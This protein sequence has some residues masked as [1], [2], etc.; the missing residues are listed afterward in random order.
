MINQ[1]QRYSRFVL[2]TLVI[3]VPL[4]SLA[5]PPWQTGVHP[6]TGRRFAG[7]M[8]MA[9][10]PWL[11]RSEREEEEAPS[12][13][14]D[15]LN[16]R[17]GMVVADVGAGVGYF[18]EPI[19]KRVGPTGL[20]YANDIQPAM[21]ELLKER[22]S[23]AGLR[24]YHTVLG[25]EDDPRLPS[26]AID[27][28]LLVDV[29]HEFSRPQEMLQKMRQAL[30]PDGRLVLLEYRKEDPGIPIRREH[31]MSVAEVKAEVEPEGFQLKTVISNRLPRQHVLIFVKRSM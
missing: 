15:L 19:A 21:L 17:Q 18:V 12:L 11:E 3:L 25:A 8:G 16:L 1:K 10:A 13:A 24:N 27:L 20:V 30:K 7:V 4:A 6:V 22:M 14:I 28:I 9:G 23:R 29:Y 2:L 5:S 26:G 31:K